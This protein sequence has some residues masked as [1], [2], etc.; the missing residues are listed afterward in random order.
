M[1]RAGW[2][3]L[4]LSVCCSAAGASRVEVVFDASGAAAHPGVGGIP[5]AATARD[6][7]AAVAAE[8]PAHGLEIG[9]RLAGGDPETSG[10]D[11]CA[12]TAV[13]VPVGAV[14]PQRWFGA[15]DAVQPHGLRPLVAAVL[16]A[17]ADLGAR[18][19]PGR[20]VVVTAGDDQC[21]RTMTEVAAA[22]SGLPSPPELRVVG[23]GLQ[24]SVS[25]RFGAVALR[26]AGSAEELTAALRWAVFEVDAGPRLRGGLRVVPEATGAASGPAVVE[27]HDLAAGASTELPVGR[28][29]PADLAVGRYRLTAAAADGTPVELRDLAVLPGVITEVVLDPG[30]GPAL[31]LD[32]V[33]PDPREGDRWRV[34]VLGLPP[35]GSA[36]VIAAGTGSAL[37][38]PLALDGQGAWLTA[39]DRPGE[40]ELLLLGPLGDGGRRVL[41]RRIASVAAAGTSV[42][43]AGEVAAGEALTVTWS[44]PA[45][46]GDAIGLVPR[47]GDA[48]RTLWCVP[49]GISDEVQLAAP[50]EKG[51]LDV[52]YLDGATW[53]VAARTPVEVTGPRAAVTAAASVVPRSRLE[54]SWEGPGA[55][56]DFVA[57]APVGSAGD[58]YL[59]WAPLA[60]GNPVALRAPTAPGDYEVRYLDGTTGEV[61]ARTPLVVTAIPIT[62]DVP[63]TAGAGL[64]FE[65]VWTGPGADG[66]FL[67]VAEEAAPPDRWYDWAPVSVGSPVSLAA[68]SRPGRYEVRY[69]TGAGREVA[70]SRAIEVRP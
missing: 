24:G 70:A 26:N 16:S 5:M 15:L 40:V 29:A 7:L 67:T 65:V 9:L 34:D 43:A 52:V 4:V 44:G 2:T 31:D 37:S 58:A 64:R 35:A 6:A 33:P 32:A 66:D 25:E 68:P 14:E 47:G 11:S 42:E 54:V 53:T 23:L 50:E 41:A 18:G 45:G 17:I 46:P 21:G 19:G 59:D 27:V 60:D 62:L 13:A 56:L 51:E 3:A 28:D 48:S 49:L 61:R 12:S 39:P 22:L 69:V 55:E 30:P 1:I 36:L 10:V 38:P 63:S 57:V 20:L 8:A